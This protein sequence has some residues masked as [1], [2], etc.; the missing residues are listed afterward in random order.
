MLL[1]LSGVWATLN[2][3]DSP[4]FIGYEIGHLI[5]ASMWIGTGA[6]ALLFRRASAQLDLQR[7]EGR[8]MLILGGVFL[9]EITVAHH[10][11]MFGP[12]GGTHHDQQ[13]QSSGLLYVASGALALALAHIGVATGAHML[14]PAVGQAI[15]ITSHIQMS[16][17]SALMHQVHAGLLVASALWRCARRVPEYSLFAALS[18]AAFIFSS[19]CPV[20]YAE[21]VALSG[22]AYVLIVLAVAA[23]LWSWAVHLACGN[24]AA[25]QQV[26]RRARKSREGAPLDDDV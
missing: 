14:L 22:A 12:T 18:G 24:I 10:G 5:P 25:A 11:G 13:H 16:E 4:G 23:L 20:R 19:E 26:E 1:L 3:F 15:M 7:L 2:C 8:L 6:L 21:D 9:L 17:Q